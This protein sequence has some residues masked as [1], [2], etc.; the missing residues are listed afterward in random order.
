M[1]LLDL[2]PLSKFG[3]GGKKP[4][5]SISP[6]PPNSLH[7]TYSADGTPT[8]KLTSTNPLNLVPQ[9][10]RLDEMDINNNNKFRSREGQKYTDNL[11]K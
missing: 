8:I 7:D 6:N 2:L 3:F 4:K 1:G 10:S 5:F 11:P 9:P